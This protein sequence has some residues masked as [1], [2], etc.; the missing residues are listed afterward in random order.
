ML[1]SRGLLELKL[2]LQ[3]AYEEREDINQQLAKAKTEEARAYRRYKS[4]DKGF[5]LKKIF[6]KTFYLRK[7]AA[8]IATAKTSELEEQLRLTSIAAT[9]ELESGQSGP[10]FQMRDDFAALADCAA[11]WNVTTERHADKVR[12]RTNVDKSI[13]RQKIS[14][15]LGSC[16]L[17]LWDEKVPHFQNTNG[18]DLFILPGLVL[19]RA[20]KRA[21]STIDV[22]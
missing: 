15:S 10:Y 11:V 22:P 18:G 4:W 21:S 14:L 12:E 16:D 13:S 6:K 7:A 19:Y 20:A 5:L 9:V 2:L 17:I 1:T 3:T 8:G